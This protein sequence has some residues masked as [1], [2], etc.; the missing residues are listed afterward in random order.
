MPSGNDLYASATPAEL[1]HSLRTPLNHV[2]GYSEMILEDL[3]D[4]VIESRPSAVADLEAILFNARE[5]VK[6]IQ[7][8]LPPEQ[9][10]VKGTEL[11][12]LQFWLRPHV[13]QLLENAASLA[14]EVRPDH[15]EDVA[16]IRAAANR[17]LAFTEGKHDALDTQ[18]QPE[19]RKNEANHEAKARVLVVDD[20]AANRDILRRSLERE[21]YAAVLAGDGR[22]ALKEIEEQA[23]DLV[24]L[25]VLMPGFSGF[26]VLQTMK[27]SPLFAA[28]PVIMISALDESSSVARCMELGA[29]DY[30]MKPFDPVLLRSRIRATLERASLKKSSEALHGGLQEALRVIGEALQAPAGQGISH[31]LQLLRDRLSEVA[32]AAI[33]FTS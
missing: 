10:Q 31:K 17:L 11:R 28:I 1:R 6:F 5:L 23:I 32:Q 26:E 7:N 12:D 4:S 25:D 2:I 3:R 8:G 22:S 15:A 14:A 18:A 33:P 24:L 13:V 29:E 16:R 9:T 27:A 19:T 30:F 20:S 21:G